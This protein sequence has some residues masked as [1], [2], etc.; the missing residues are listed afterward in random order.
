MTGA[1]RRDTGNP[2]GRRGSRPLLCA[3]AALLTAFAL[4]F[5]LPESG[6]SRELL[7]YLAEGFRARDLLFTALFLLCFAFYRQSRLRA[8]PF[9]LSAALLGL[10]FALFTVLGRAFELFNSWKP[11][12]DAPAHSLVTALCLLGV[13]KLAYAALRWILGRADRL[14]RAEAEP[15]LSAPA[16]WSAFGLIL[17]G[18]L[19]W[20]AL[21]F[22]G[23]LSQD[24]SNQIAQ[25]LGVIPPSSH[26]PYAASWLMGTVYRLFGEGTGGL[27]ANV[28][29]QAL[30]CAAAYAFSCTAV[31]GFAGRRAGR[32]SVAFFAL[33]PL[34]GAYAQSLMKDTVHAGCFAAFSAC[35]MLFAARRGALKPGLLILLGLSALLCVLTRN[36]GLYIVVPALAVLAFPARRLRGRL[37]ALGLAAGVLSLS[38][39]FNHLLLPALNVAPGPVSEAFSLPFQVTARCCLEHPE[40][41]RPEERAAIDAVLDY[42]E[43]LKVYDPMVSDLVKNSYRG[44]ASALPAYFKTWLRM[45]LRHPLT[46]CQAALNSCY[47]YFSPGCLI[48]I[49][50]GAFFGSAGQDFGISVPHALPELCLAAERWNLIC[51]HAPGLSALY[52]PSTYTWLLLLCTA[53]LLRKRRFRRAAAQLPLWLAL[54]ACCLSPVNG[55][56]RY[57]LPLMAAA[58]ALCGYTV[59]ALTAKEDADRAGA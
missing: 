11:L 13:W 3:L 16:F 46:Y 38:L 53:A 18:W 32:L 54:A 49:F 9:S 48:G 8:E 30:V 50:G 1:L 42:D 22:P 19:P 33:L 12:Y 17:A 29:L 6:G 2:R 26:H 14:P 5:R 34:W 21:C 35:C 44:D 59:H 10:A 52:T 7:V 58:P 31:R 57:A 25:I 36:S 20:L 47:G 39:L 41:L 37:T 43:I 27:F 15:A 56:V 28:L 51:S 4:A 40:D 45:G 55:L 23:S 24:A